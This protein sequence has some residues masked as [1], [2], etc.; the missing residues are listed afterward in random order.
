MILKEI[1]R[2]SIF[3]LFIF[4]ACKGENKVKTSN[5]EVISDSSETKISN[6]WKNGKITDTTAY[7]SIGNPDTAIVLFYH[8]NLDTVN[9]DAFI[10]Y[11]RLCEEEDKIFRIYRQLF[12][13]EKDVEDQITR[14][15]K[16][17][18]KIVDST[19]SYLILDFKTYGY[20]SGSS[21]A[22]WLIF[23]CKDFKIIQHLKG[24]LGSGKLSIE[25]KRKIESDLNK[26]Q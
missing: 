7:I 10:E 25:D 4:F 6:L 3:G 23:K 11:C 24:L 12:H 16:L 18:E 19:R 15:K 14:I 2:I 17:K 22:D 8:Q 9:Y 13:H 5:L 26:I 20:D 1:N 21:E